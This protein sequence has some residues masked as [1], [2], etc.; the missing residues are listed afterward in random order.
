MLRYFQLILFFLFF[1]ITN[2]ANANPQWL[3]LPPTP[4]LPKAYQSGYAPI[5]GERIWYAEFGSG[6]P[7]ILLHGAL[8]NSNYWGLQVPVLAQ[9]YR[10]I[11]MDT[12]GHGRS[13]STNQVYS[14]DLMASDVVKLMDYLK[15]KKAAIVGWSDGAIVGLT[16]AI[17][18]PDRLSKLFAFGANSNPAGLREDLPASNV[19]IAYAARA[20][21]EYENLS[22]TPQQY[23]A[24]AEKINTMME[25]QPNFTKTQLNAITTPVWIVDGDRD[26]AIKRSDTEFMAAEIP[27]AGL[28]ILP[29]VSHFA[30]LQ[31]PEQFNN[32]LLHFLKSK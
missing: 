10:V 5:N 32:D 7:V 30:F 27:N 31:D 12:R 1:L 13:Q 24:F 22:S 29:E 17:N 2:L 8:A 6:Q 25:T 26:E 4:T 21:L 20:K 16:I 11:V 19:D 15:I 28:L 14:Y 3:Q 9:H 23:Q 18:Y